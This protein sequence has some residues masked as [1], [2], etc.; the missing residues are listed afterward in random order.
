MKLKELIWIGSS[1][2]DLM[3]FPEDVISAMGYSL[4]LAQLG[5]KHKNVKPLKGFGGADVLEIVDGTVSG[6]YRGVYTTKYKDMV[7][8]L[9]AFQKKSKQ[10]IKT[11]KSEIDLIDNRLKQAQEIYKDIMDKRV[12]KS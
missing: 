10:G 5:E 6:T 11:P 9:H 7:F 2:K 4:Y 8:V 12:Q 3:G 1:K